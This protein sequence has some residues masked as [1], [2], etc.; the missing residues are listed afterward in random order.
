MLSNKF[1][2]LL[3]NIKLPLV[4]RTVI[5]DD[6]ITK[7]C[8]TT[9]NLNSAHYNRLSSMSTDSSVLYLKFWVQIVNVIKKVLSCHPH[10]NQLLLRHFD[11]RGA[12]CLFQYRRDRKSE[13][14]IFLFW[15]PYSK[16][17]DYGDGHSYILSRVAAQTFMPTR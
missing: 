11:Y 5:A 16:G 2:L 4:V 12:S 10:K 3:D 7:Q 17:Y 8:K 6:I 13:V 15:A 14:R 1:L 9:D